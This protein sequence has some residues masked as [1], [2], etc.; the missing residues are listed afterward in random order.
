MAATR[1]G[2]DAPVWVVTG[3]DAAGVAPRQPKPS[4]QL[5]LRDHFAV[6]VAAAGVVPLPVPGR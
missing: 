2:E 1:Q 6:A 5:T 3:T 4:M